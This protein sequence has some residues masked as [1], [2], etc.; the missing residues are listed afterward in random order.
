M[1]TSVPTMVEAWL[2]VHV[3]LWCIVL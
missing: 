1:N 2:Y 3:L